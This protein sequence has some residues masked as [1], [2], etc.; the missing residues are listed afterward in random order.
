MDSVSG[1]TVCCCDCLIFIANF[2][3]FGE[4]V[5]GCFEEVM[6]FLREVGPNVGGSEDG[7]VDGG[8][9]DQECGM[10][11]PSDWYEVVIAVVAVGPLAI[12]V[13]YL[14]RILCS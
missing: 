1:I 4:A 7:G 3:C 11:F 9:A 5:A 6:D 14:V 2:E 8:N 10:R 13:T 12:G